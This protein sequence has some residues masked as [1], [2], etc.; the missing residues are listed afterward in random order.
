MHLLRFH[1][2]LHIHALKSAHIAEQRKM[3]RI[4][5]VI[6]RLPADLRSLHLKLLHQ[7]RLI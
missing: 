2:L 4:Y 1:L 7:S 3:K 5:S 6:D